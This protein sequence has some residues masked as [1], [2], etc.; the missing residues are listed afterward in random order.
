M[1]IEPLVER[2]VKP[3]ISDIG[4]ANASGEALKVQEKEPVAAVQDNE[5]DDD[6]DSYFYAEC[7]DEALEVSKTHQRLTL[8]GYDNPKKAGG[9]VR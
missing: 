8:S 4:K 7:Y 5:L 1:G 3:I 6:V 9:V 2:K